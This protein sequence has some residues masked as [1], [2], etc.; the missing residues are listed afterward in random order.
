MSIK[1]RARV[2]LSNRKIGEP[3]LDTGMITQDQ[4][5]PEFNPQIPL[6]PDE[7]CWILDRCFSYE[8]SKYQNVVV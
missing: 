4:I 5:R 2:L 1:T 3:R 6:L 8:V 7:L